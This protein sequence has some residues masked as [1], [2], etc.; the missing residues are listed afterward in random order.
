MAV[1]PLVSTTWLAERLDD[2]TVRVV[3]IRG[4][5]ITRSPEPGVEEALYQAAYNEYAAGHIPGAV[6]V[7]WTLDIVDPGSPVPVQL[8]DP[9][10]FAEAMAARGIGDA[11]HV[12]A[13]DHKGGQFATRLWWALRHYGHA[14]V[15][16][17]EGGMNRWLEER[18]PVELQVRDWPRGDFS[19]RPRS[20]SRVTA[21]ELAARLGSGEYDLIDARDE[22]QYSGAKRRGPRGGHIPGAISLPRERFLDESGNHRSIDELR[23]LATHAGLDAAR[24]VIAYCNGGVAATVALF[25]LHRLGFENL[26][27]YDGSWNEWSG[28]VELPVETGGGSE[29][30]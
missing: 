2:P 11:T 19:A 12:I 23:S 10:R 9:R 17:L 30:L 15:S 27:N 3:D 18:R 22:A 24:P 25:N 16:V 6:Y 20:G 29:R 13:V 7:D 28:R 5:V 4:Y 8:A 26:A 21:E 1:D 14:A